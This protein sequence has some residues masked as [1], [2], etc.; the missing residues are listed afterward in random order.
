MSRRSAAVALRPFTYAR[1][2]PSALTRRARTSS[3]ASSASR[4]PSDARSAFGR[5]NAPSTYASDAPGR[6]MPARGLP[7]S[8]RS[9]ACASTVLPAP[10]SP[11]STLSPGPSRS[12]ARSISRRFSTRS[13]SSTRQ[14]LPAGPDGPGPRRRGG[15]KSVPLCDNLRC[16]ATAR[17]GRS[18]ARVSP[19]AFAV[20][21]RG[22][23]PPVVRGAR[24]VVGDLEPGGRTRDEISAADGHLPGRAGRIRRLRRVRVA[25]PA[26]V[27][28]S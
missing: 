13:S 25:G 19:Q 18:P 12:S 9:S 14:G 10:V 17:S 5:S 26:T 15:T 6:T 8:S 16:R 3:S 2:R 7:P 20:E 1:V 22:G 23:D 11:V 21:S 28:S 24:G 4:S 27:T